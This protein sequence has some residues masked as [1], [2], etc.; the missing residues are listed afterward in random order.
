MTEISPH[1]LNMIAGVMT[2]SFLEDPLM[3][4]VFNGIPNMRDI[5]F[6]HARLQL[7]FASKN[8]ELIFVDDN[9][10]AFLIGVDS[11][12]E[13]KFAESWLYFRI[14]LKTLNMLRPS[15]IPKILANNNR[16]SR[17]LSLSWQKKFVKGRHY[18]IKI[19]AIDKELRGSG[20]FRRL[21]SPVIEFCDLKKIPIIL[22]T[23]NP[24][25]VPIYQRFGFEVVDTRS[26]PGMDLKQYCMLRPAAT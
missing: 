7:D 10:L 2:N 22:E 26:A 6:E 18:H 21:I 1:I 3:Q 23:H 19:I 5:I 12:H 11:K 13:K 14:M 25:N 8:Q 24:N 9:P 16:A 20:I 4:E 17:V 15:Q